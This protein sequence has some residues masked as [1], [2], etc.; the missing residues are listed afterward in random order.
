MS[1]VGRCW[2]F[3]WCAAGSPAGEAAATVLGQQQWSIWFDSSWAKSYWSRSK[4]HRAS[5]RQSPR[6]VEPTSVQLHGTTLSRQL[7][8]NR[9]FWKCSGTFRI[10]C[11]VIDTLGLYSIII[12]IFYIFLIFL[13]LVFVF[14]ISVF[15]P[16][17]LHVSIF[18]E[19]PQYPGS[20]AAQYGSMSA[21]P[22]PPAVLFNTGSGQLPAQAGGLYGA[23]QLDQS[24]SPFTQYPPYAPSLQNSFSQQNVYL[25]QPPPPPPHAPNAPTPDMYQS[26]LSQYR[27]VSNCLVQSHIRFH[28]S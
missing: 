27:I 6:T 13:L 10:F 5:S 20:Q 25:Q 22:S 17:H 24:R 16:L 18:Q 19:F 23:F 9:L 8:G 15:L 1:P 11:I 21:I 2:L 12:F 26:N 3:A 14:S 7:S 4:S 28:N